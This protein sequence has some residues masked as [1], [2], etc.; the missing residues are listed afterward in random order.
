MASRDVTYRTSLTWLPGEPDATIKA[1]IHD[2]EPRQPHCPG[3]PAHVEIVAVRLDG[4][5]TW[6]LRRKIAEFDCPC[7]DALCAEVLANQNGSL[8]G[9]VQEEEE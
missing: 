5:R 6:V 3:T 2:E 8:R 9:S 7:Y 4:E 1:V